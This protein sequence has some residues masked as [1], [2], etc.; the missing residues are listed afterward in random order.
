MA[1]PPVVVTRTISPQA[2]DRLREQADPVCWSADCP[3]PRE[4]LRDHLVEA[5]GL[6][7]LLTDSIDQDL[8]AEAKQLRVVSTVSVGF[9][10]IDVEFCTDRN[11]PVGYTPGVL[12]E[13]TADLAF[14]LL[15]AGARRIVEGARYVQDG[16][17]TEWKP[18]LLLGR[19]VYGAT[20][21]IVGFG[22][23][24]QAMARRAQGFDMRV[25]AVTSASSN[26]TSTRGLSSQ[27][28]VSH[29]GKVSSVE[30][31]D[32]PTALAES[33]FVSLHVPL[34]AQTQHLL[35][36]SEF[37]RM[38]PT[39]VLINTA[40]G[41]VVDTEA[42]YEALSNGTIAGAALDVTD[43]EPLPLSHP[44]HQ[45]PNCVVIP[46]LGSASTATRE[47]MASMAV[48]NVLAGLQGRVLPYC[49]NPQIY[50]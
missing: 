23:I 50:D 30:A 21:G 37:Q 11:I 35:G 40:R 28:T 2:W 29:K 26:P 22:R 43:P 1:H 7:C 31:V 48:E 15:L 24:G 4:W 17:W 33:D 27:V 14:S 32:L 20:L 18:D 6:L 44:L 19:D 12:T 9:N 36:R 41:A 8:L 34:T 49:V 13:T 5:E 3:V 47:K 42:L 39:S 16:Q 45:L 10:H 25:V 38:K 46:H